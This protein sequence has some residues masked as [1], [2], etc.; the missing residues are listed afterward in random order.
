MK[1]TAQTHALQWLFSLFIQMWLA[2]KMAAKVIIIPRDNSNL[3]Y[4]ENVY[5]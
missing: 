4:L 2:V 3:I 1:L 5:L